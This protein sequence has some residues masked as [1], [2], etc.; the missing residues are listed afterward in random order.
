MSFRRTFLQAAA[1]AV[2]SASAS[3]APAQSRTSQLH[4]DLE[5]QAA[6]DLQTRAEP[7]GGGA[8]RR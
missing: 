6:F 4:D 5:Q 7:A 1:V 8:Q 3:P 2:L